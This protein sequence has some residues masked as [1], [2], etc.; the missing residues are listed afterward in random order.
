M[1]RTCACLG[2]PLAS[3]RPKRIAN[4][5]LISVQTPLPVYWQLWHCALLHMMHVEHQCMQFTLGPS[6]ADAARGFAIS[7]YK[8]PPGGLLK[9]ESVQSV[10]IK[11]DTLLTMADQQWHA[12]GAPLSSTATPLCGTSPQSSTKAGSFRR[13][14]M[15]AAA[16]AGAW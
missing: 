5:A 2:Q 11:A 16:P 9:T 6:Q 15:S 8:S 12:Y 13:S 3:T 14:I 7:K 4:P 1:V 10:E